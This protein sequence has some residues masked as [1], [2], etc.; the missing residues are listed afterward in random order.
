MKIT[1]M[2]CLE[3]E[4]EIDEVNGDKDHVWA[5]P[6]NVHQRYMIRKRSE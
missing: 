2:V 5:R 1:E 3:I 4:C 6:V